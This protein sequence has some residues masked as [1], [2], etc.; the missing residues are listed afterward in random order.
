MHRIAHLLLLCA[1][2][3]LQAAPLARPYTVENYDVGVH[4]D[5]ANQRLTGEASIRFHSL[6]NEPISALEFDAGKLQISS[7]TEGGLPQ[8]I[9]RDRSLLLVVLTR[10]LRPDESRTITVR[11]QTGAGAG[12]T[13]TADQVCAFSPGGWLPSNNRPGER[14]TLHLKITAP[15]TAKITA[16]GKETGSG[17]W[18]LDQPTEPSL[19]GF[20]GGNFSEETSDAGGIKL[21]VLGADRSFLDVTAA[22][23]RDFAGRTGKR[24]PAQTY[25]EVFGHLD[26]PRTLAGLTLLPDSYS[27]NDAASLA[28]A[29]AHQWFGVAIAPKNWPDLWLSDGLAGF[30][31][32]TYIGTRSGKPAFDAAIT[33]SR[34]LYKQLAAAGKDH[35]LSNT[36]WASREDTES[37]LAK[38]KGVLFLYQAD[39]LMGDSAFWD[40][41]RAFTGAHWNQTATTED[42]QAALD[43]ANG[44][45]GRN[46]KTG[47]TPLDSL[48]DQWDYGILELKK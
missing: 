39:Q 19:F 17:E 8:A 24:Y 25:T 45:K 23:L 27:S 34:E 26:A 32:D 47:L 29:I 20:A 33:R 15:G 42:L 14:A 35:P 31:A 10:P 36:E 16:S 44:N 11:Y 18:E 30:L 7:V 1:I 9:E 6:V 3:F 38:N 21:R 22:I 12:L 41:I 13:F 43:A 4:V 2:P 5:I 37:A 48:F 28:D 40:G 46:R